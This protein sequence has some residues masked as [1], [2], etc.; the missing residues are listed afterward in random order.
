MAANPADVPIVCFSHL[1]WD[2]RLFQRPQ[3]IMAGLARRGHPVYYFACVGRSAHIS[4][5]MHG[6]PI[7]GVRVFTLP[8]SPYATR[9][10]NLR[11]WAASL[12]V[13]RTL[14]E[15]RIHRPVLWFYHPALF[16]LGYAHNDAAIVYDVMDH[17][18]SF[19]E[20][21]HD[22]YFDELTLLAESDLV[23]TGGRSLDAHVRQMLGEL[24][25]ASTAKPHV[26]VICLP[27]GVDLDHFAQARQI[28]TPPSD[29]PVLGYFGAIDERIDW[30][31]LVRLV[32]ILE[33]R[34]V[35]VGPQIGERP[36][37]LPSRIEVRP[38]VEY[39]DLPQVLA[40]FDV[41]LL[42]FKMTTLV[43]YIS[44]TKTPEYLAGGKPVVSTAV[45]DVI[46]DYSGVVAVGRTP[47]EFIAACRAAI[48][49]P[50]PPDSM[51]AAAHE[52][53]RTWN[54]I[55]DEIAEQLQHLAKAH[56]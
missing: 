6:E 3:H 21:A 23:I 41:C 12:K 40:G 18:S 38:S 36:A 22:Y 42:P 28:S 10:H 13:A 53:A 47:E 37:S 19:Q 55:T 25:A 49:E 34:V 50:P 56:R 2:K 54:Q 20:G 1:G 9:L 26:P 31:L 27:S 7:D 35:L 45:P 16:P 4:Q 14:A 51:T 15:H 33:C 46:A 17:F 32:N 29:L 52:R 48:A 30:D 39:K 44:P 11:R 5:P 8:W 24:A 43:Q